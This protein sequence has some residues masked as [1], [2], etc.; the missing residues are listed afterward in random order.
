MLKKIGIGFVLLFATGAAAVAI[1]WFGWLTPPDAT[2]VCDN[3]DRVV[4]ADAD[5]LIRK[6]DLPKALVDEALGKAK[7]ET[8]AHCERFSTKKPLM[9]AQAIWVKRLECMR[10]ADDMGALKRCDAISSF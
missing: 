3:V 6:R 7:Q 5:A 9:L 8:H 4:E 1:F 2:A 10:D